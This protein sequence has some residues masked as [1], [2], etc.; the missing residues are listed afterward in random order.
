M[1][2]RVPLE[3]GGRNNVDILK[4]VKASTRLTAFYIFI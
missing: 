2:T 3:L 1:T 4:L